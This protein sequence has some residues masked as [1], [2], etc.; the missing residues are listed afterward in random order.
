MDIL[1]AKE[2]LH[3]SDPEIREMAEFELEDS[4]AKLETVTEE[5][6]AFVAEMVSKLPSS[7]VNAYISLLA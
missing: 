5:Y 3:E 2:L 4:K 6:N 1:E 7:F